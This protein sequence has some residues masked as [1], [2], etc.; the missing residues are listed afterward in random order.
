MARVPGH[1]GLQ[2][3][4]DVSFGLGVS[5]AWDLFGYVGLIV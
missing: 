5:G 2:A 4:F 3:I 1:F